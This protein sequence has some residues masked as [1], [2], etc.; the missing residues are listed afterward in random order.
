IAAAFVLL[1][2]SAELACAQTTADESLLESVQSPDIGSAG[3]PSLQWRRET[4]GALLNYCE[5]ALSLIPRNSP[6][7]DQSMET[8]ENSDLSTMPLEFARWRLA[9]IFGDCIQLTQEIRNAGK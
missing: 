4:A 5:A 9:A 2:C 7:E 3:F 6:R 1:C 8:E